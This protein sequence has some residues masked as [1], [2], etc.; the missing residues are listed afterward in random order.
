MHRSLP[1][2]LFLL[3][4][5]ACSG[6]PAV[7][8]SPDG[9]YRVVHLADCGFDAQRAHASMQQA[10]ATLSEI[11]LVFAHDDAM[12]RA[13]K[14]ALRSAGKP[15]V[16]VIGVDALPDAGRRLVEDGTLEVSIENPTGADVALDLAV[17]ACNGVQLPREITLG[18]RVF[19]HG[20][21][22]NQRI[23]SAGDVL[24]TM[25]RA[26]HAAEL[27][28]ARTLRI[29]VA[30]CTEGEPW[31]QAMRNDIESW[32]RTHAS[33][34]VSYRSADGSKERQRDL[35]AAFVAEKVDA[36]VVS[37]I[38]AGALIEPCKLARERGIPVI[39][40]DRELGSP[41]FT[42]FV[43]GDNL[44]IGRA[45]GLETARLLPNGGAIVELQG[46][47]TTSTARDR[48]NGFSESLQLLAPQ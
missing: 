13:A 4:L 29:G 41:D 20:T 17:L 31:R 6:D 27:S 45:A 1:T 28:A 23:P 25:L 46:L 36:I 43:T 37:P 14:D 44:A 7:L 33:V 47:M 40:L 24:L 9:K 3:A 35:V 30:Q 48:H 32:A 8:Q 18:T 11:D 16:K 15:L 38:E 26:Q 22:T 12:A 42:C 21:S 5:P 2:V 34:Q 10:L 19:A 39:V